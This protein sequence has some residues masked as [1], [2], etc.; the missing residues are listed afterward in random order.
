MK[1]LR[2]AGPCPPR[3]AAVGEAAGVPDEILGKDLNLG[4]ADLSAVRSVVLLLPPLQNVAN[5]PS[6]ASPVQSFLG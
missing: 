2:F 1:R 6:S 5:R 3:R 4:R